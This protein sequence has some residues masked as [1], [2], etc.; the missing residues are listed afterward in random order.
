MIVRVN[1]EA[2]AI[3]KGMKDIPTM[4]LWFEINSISRPFNSKFRHISDIPT[5]RLMIITAL[6]VLITFTFS[7]LIFLLLPE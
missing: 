3:P 4:A 6:V 7:E 1:R 5:Q 2:R